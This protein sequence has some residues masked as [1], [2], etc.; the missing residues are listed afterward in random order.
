MNLLNYK[1]LRRLK[2]VG[3]Y[4]LAI[5]SISVICFPLYWM[6]LCSFRPLTELFKYPPRLIPTSF[7]LD[8]YRTLFRETSFGT[9]FLNS[10]VT[11][12]MSVLVTI[13]V[14]LLAGYSLTRYRYRGKY[15]LMCVILT[16]Y[17]FSK[18]IYVIPLFVIFAKL[19][20]TDSLVGLGIAYITHAL[21]FSA[22][23]I[24]GFYGGFPWELED[25]AMVDG[26]TR[27]QAFLK[28]VFPLSLPGIIAIALY[29]FVSA[30]NDYL[31]AF[32]FISSEWKR[33][34]PVGLSYFFQVTDVQWG[35][36]M[37][38]IVLITL[39]ITIVFM[40]IQRHLIRGFTAGAIKE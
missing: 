14:S 30:W 15:V 29:V 22:W 38:A 3:I 27:R 13:T 7:T 36:L 11:A 2:R 39:P 17:M 1:N 23:L 26:A 32:V 28:I 20:L 25:A 24:Y 10:T 8:N 34:I 18:A 37:P 12:G 4:L 16:T 9:Y 6:V 31:Y 33:T 21:P 19:Y 40:V 35:N 5:I